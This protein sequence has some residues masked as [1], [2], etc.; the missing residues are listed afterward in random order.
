MR[1]LDSD[2]N[3]FFSVLIYSN[4]KSFVEPLCVLNRFVILTDDSEVEHRSKM[5][6]I[7]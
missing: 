5:A 7:N 3:C 2:T 4:D 1:A 6:Y